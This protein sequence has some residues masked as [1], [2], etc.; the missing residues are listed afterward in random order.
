MIPVETVLRPAL[1]GARPVRLDHD[2]A[3]HAKYLVSAL[4]LAA[5]LALSAA[6][7]V[8]GVDSIMCVTAAL[9]FFVLGMH[10]LRG[11]VSDLILGRARTDPAWGGI[12]RVTLARHWE[13]LALAVLL[14]L[15]AAYLAAVLAGEPA[16]YEALVRSV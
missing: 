5:M 6:G 10:C 12:M 16:Y 7:H 11:I 15:Y 8:T 13:E 9:L 4:V 2:R 1:A 3:A 14:A